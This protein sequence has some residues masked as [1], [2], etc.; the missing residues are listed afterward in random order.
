MRRAS[1][2]LN[3]LPCVGQQH[4]SHALPDY[5]MHSTSFDISALYKK[6]VKN[7][8]TT[9]PH[10]T[11][12]RGVHIKT[13]VV[14]LRSFKHIATEGGLGD[15]A[16]RKCFSPT[17]RL[18]VSVAQIAWTLME[19]LGEKTCAPP[20]HECP[21]REHPKRRAGDPHFWAG[22]KAEKHDKKEF[23]ELNFCCYNVM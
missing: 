19:D 21:S 12:S 4:K 17:K 18:E 8:R 16:I 7:A 22:K 15:E 1:R 14:Y 6:C 9:L 13:L 11:R 10:S 23:E 20:T 2:L 3:F 5:A